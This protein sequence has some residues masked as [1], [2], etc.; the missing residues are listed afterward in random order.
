MTQK[1]NSLFPIPSDFN[2]YYYDF[3]FIKS[4]NSVYT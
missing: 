2:K 4:L 3:V 1:F